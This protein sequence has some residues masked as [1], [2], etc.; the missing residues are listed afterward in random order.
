MGVLGLSSVLAKTRSEAKDL[1]EKLTK[2]SGIIGVIAVIWGVVDLVDALINIRAIGGA[3]L[4]WICWIV[5]AL[6][7]IGLGFIFGYNMAKTILSEEA[8]AK[9]EELRQKLVAFQ[10]PLGWASLGMAALWIL[11]RFI[12]Y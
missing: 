1:I 10:I 3:P 7:F 11:V 9:G 2:V 12:I 6:L 8:R 4:W 5:T